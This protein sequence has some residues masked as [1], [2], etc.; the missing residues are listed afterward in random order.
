M[1]ILRIDPNNPDKTGI[2][3]NLVM[4]PYDEIL[5]CDNT[6]LHI[7]LRNLDYD[8]ITFPELYKILTT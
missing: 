3:I 6:W 1:R 4:Q 5:P 7:G 8:F 2:M